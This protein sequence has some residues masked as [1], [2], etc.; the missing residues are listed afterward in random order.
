MQINLPEMKLPLSPQL[1]SCRFSFNPK[2]FSHYNCKQKKNSFLS[3][4]SISSSCEPSS[5]YHWYGFNAVYLLPFLF[6]G[7]RYKFPRLRSKELADSL[8]H[9][10]MAPCLYTNWSSKNKCQ[11]SKACKS[12]LLRGK[13]FKMSW[14]T[15]VLSLQPRF[16]SIGNTKT[17]TPVTLTKPQKT[18]SPL[19][20]TCF[21][22]IQ[23]KKIA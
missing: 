15:N 23:T 2:S 22:K 7:S 19:V 16:Q 11:T 21:C 3:P 17:H 20:R 14:K 6:L 10:H 8:L 12:F 9:F 13:V 5:E 1:R 4:E 18:E